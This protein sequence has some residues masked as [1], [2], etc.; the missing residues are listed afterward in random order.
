MSNAQTQAQTLTRKPI[1]AQRSAQRS[2]APTDLAMSRQ[3]QGR[4]WSSSAYHAS[5]SLQPATHCRT[6]KTLGATD[7]GGGHG[8]G[9]DGRGE[10]GDKIQ[11]NSN[12][13]D[14]DSDDDDNN[15]GGGGIG[16][17]GSD[18]NNTAVAWVWGRQESQTEGGQKLLL[19]ISSPPSVA[20]N[21][22]CQTTF[23]SACIALEST[24]GTPSAKPPLD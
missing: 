2:A 24:P 13:N 18:G 20:H 4:L 10:K 22:H 5:S 14:D 8:G 6:S 17:G 3:K 11:M 19:A 9:E 21:A 16:R 23:D 15:G 7:D 1:T 12:A